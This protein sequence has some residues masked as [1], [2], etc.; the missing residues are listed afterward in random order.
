MHV[1]SMLSLVAALSLGVGTS[2]LTARAGDRDANAKSEEKERARDQK[3]K[4]HEDREESGRDVGRD[5]GR[6]GENADEALMIRLK[7]LESEVRSLREQVAGLQK[8][9]KDGAGHRDEAARAAKLS[10]EAERKM[11]ELKKGQHGKDEK[12]AGAA[13][14]FAAVGKVTKGDPGA[15]F[16]AKKPEADAKSL[17]GQPEP[18]H[19][20][21]PGTDAKPMKGDADAKHS[22]KSDPDARSVKG[23][24]GEKHFKKP[25]PDA[26]SAKDGTKGESKN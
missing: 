17:K 5:V 24:G 23:E 6:K 21:K 10:P 16:A 22:K 8:R 26:K 11:A 12:D 1:R 4:A 14:K 7:R 25:D 18:K 13:K 3:R 9:L 2:A 15:K 19:V 20:K